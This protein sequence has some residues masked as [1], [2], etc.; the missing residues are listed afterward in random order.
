MKKN[1]TWKRINKMNKYYLLLEL[2]TY[3]K[4]TSNLTLDSTK[5]LTLLHSTMSINQ[6][7]HDLYTITKSI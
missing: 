2:V 6:L 1:L 7:R 4:K 3:Y 5:I